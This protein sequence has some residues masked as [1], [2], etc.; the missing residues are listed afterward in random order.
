[1]PCYFRK[2]VQN[3]EEK[4]VKRVLVFLDNFDTGGVTSVVKTIYR[5]IN[6]KEYSMDFVRRNCNVNE[7]DAEIKKD[8]NMIYYY[9]DCG[10]NS[11]P[12]INYK[13]RQ[14]HI[15]KQ[16]LKQIKRGKIEYDAIHVHANPII[17]LFIGKKLNIP[18][19]IMH[20]HEAI[21]DFGDNIHTS[22]IMNFIWKQR[23]QKYNTWTTIKAGDSKKACIAKYGEEVVYDPKMEILYPPI[24]MKKFDKTNYD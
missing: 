9:E 16:V 22:K 17:G 18:V 8:G 13:R 5:N 4:K 15:A 10:L 7:F 20:T 21:P 3:Q 12:V 1:M 2:N 23:R 6:S 11:I 14:L 24:D 19:R